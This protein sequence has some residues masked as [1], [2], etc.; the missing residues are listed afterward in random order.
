[1]W[2]HI[3]TS[4]RPLHIYKSTTSS[5]SKPGLF[6]TTTLTLLLPWFVD[7]FTQNSRIRSLTDS[8]NGLRFSADSR[9]SQR[10]S[11]EQSL[12]WIPELEDLRNPGRQQLRFRASACSWL[13][14]F[15]EPSFPNSAHLRTRDF[16]G[17]R[18]PAFA[19]FLPLQNILWECH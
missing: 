5:H 11:P 18:V 17:L 15:A 1:M 19:N 16:A 13:H 3:R 10:L 12:H 9:V 4:F 6:G 7:V 8:R 14:I 2:T